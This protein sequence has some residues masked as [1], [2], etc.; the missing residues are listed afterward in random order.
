MAHILELLI[1]DGDGVDVRCIYAEIVGAGGNRRI[2]RVHVG[3]W[4]AGCKPE[5]A[6][7]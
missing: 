4:T 3:P 7:R 2:E 5:L 1:F 6:A